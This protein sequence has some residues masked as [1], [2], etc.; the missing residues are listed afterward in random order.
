MDVEFA[1]NDLEL[2]ATDEKATMG[3]PAHVAKKYRDRIAFIQAAPDERA[4]RALQ[5]SLDYKKLKGG[6]D[7]ERQMRLNKKYRI[8]LE[9]IER[10]EGK[11]L[12]IIGVGDF[13][14]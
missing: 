14:D 13:H 12:R 5:G 11:V 4:L 6:A 8:R 7:N 1:T 3:L 2:L 10:D 9:V